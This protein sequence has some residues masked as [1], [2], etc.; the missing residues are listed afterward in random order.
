MKSHNKRII[1]L[2]CAVLTICTIF[3]I[4]VF[5]AYGDVHTGGNSSNELA[6]YDYGS[7]VHGSTYAHTATSFTIKVYTTLKTGDVI[8]SDEVFI[9][10]NEGG[11][12]AAYNSRASRAYNECTAYYSTGASNFAR[13]WCPL[14]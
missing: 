9:R 14:N 10:G 12:D 5:A 4:T 11:T 7:Y 13:M 1:R 6:I 2:L 3:A 8:D